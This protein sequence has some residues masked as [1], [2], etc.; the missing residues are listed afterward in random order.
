MDMAKDLPPLTL[1]NTTAPKLVTLIPVLVSMTTRR[2]IPCYDDESDK[3][4]WW[5]DDIRWTNPKAYV[6]GGTQNGL[7]ILR[8]LVHSCYSYH[9]VEELLCMIDRSDYQDLSPD[10]MDIIQLTDDGDDSHSFSPGDSSQESDGPVYVCCF[11]LEQFSSHEEVNSHQS[12]CQKKFQTSSRAGNAAVTKTPEK[13]QNSASQRSPVKAVSVSAVSC[14]PPKSNSSATAVAVSWQPSVVKSQSSSSQPAVVKSQSSSHVSS[15]KASSQSSSTSHPPPSSR[16]ISSALS[17]NNKKP[18]FVPILKTR[19]QKRLDQIMEKHNSKRLMMK[20]CKEMKDVPK[21][22]AW[23]SRKKRRKSKPSR[24]SHPSDDFSK[25]SFISALGLVEKRVLEVTEASKKETEVDLDCEII[26]VEGPLSSTTCTPSSAPPQRLGLSSPRSKSLMSQL[27]RDSEPSSRRR[28]SFCFVEDEWADKEAMEE[29]RDPLA[30]SLLTLDFSSPLG[31]RVKKYVKGESCLNIIK[32]PDQYCRT[33]EMDNGYSKLRF[34]GSD[35]RVTYRKKRRASSFVHKYKFNKRDVRE[36][37]KLLKTGLSARTRRLLRCIPHCRVKL[38]KMSETEIRNWRERTITISDKIYYDDDVCIT[39]IDLPESLVEKGSTRENLAS[40]SAFPHLQRH[41]TTPSNQVQRP[42]TA[43]QR[44]AASHRH[45]PCPSNHRSLSLPQANSQPHVP[46]I[47][48]NRQ[49][50]APSPPRQGPQLHRHLTSANPQRVSSPMPSQSNTSQSQSQVNS[51]SV[52]S[53]SLTKSVAKENPHPDKSHPEQTQ[54]T[55][56]NNLSSAPPSVNHTE[57]LREIMLGKTSSNSQSPNSR[58]KQQL[59]DVRTED[60][61]LPHK[62]STDSP[63]CV[64][65]PAHQVNPFSMLSVNHNTLKSP[66]P[67]HQAS[68]SHRAGSNPMSTLSN[69]LPQSSS[70]SCTHRK[71]NTHTESPSQAHHHK[72]HNVVMTSSD[73]SERHSSRSASGK[74]CVNPTSSSQSSHGKHSRILPRSNHV[75]STAVVERTR[76][77]HL[78]MSKVIPA[79][80]VVNNSNLDDDDDDVLEVICIDD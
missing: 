77:L 21:E 68:L 48:R 55:S 52:V 23:W 61:E 13:K 2:A 39:Q 53:Q 70:S 7:Q 74:S 71:H 26:L 17:A 49:G 18:A 73:S 32:D 27:S 56:L 34:R 9:G 20:E 30:T 15:V 67:A 72:S 59:N 42:S 43:T 12:L 57:A 36:F 41:L 19:S 29:G 40:N 69:T 10:S 14:S 38:K 16:V 11:C 47:F 25:R 37:K 45:V 46:N 75:T 78:E 35:F 8:K 54:P 80:P 63:D 1:K 5:P 65:P 60:F 64:P 58:R 31:Q 28:I 76:D 4:A 50:Y 79:P 6:Q 66:L 3:P 33:E 44:P 24:V 51:C 62:Q 22:G